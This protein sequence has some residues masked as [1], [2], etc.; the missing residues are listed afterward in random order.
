MIFG[1]SG[2]SD[3]FGARWFRRPCPNCRTF[4]SP[5]RLDAQKRVETL[6]PRHGRGFADFIFLFKRISLQKISRAESRIAFGG[7]VKYEQKIK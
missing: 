2:L 3:F 7:N 5:A 1:H 6:F 4:C